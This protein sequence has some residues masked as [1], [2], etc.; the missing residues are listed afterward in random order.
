MGEQDFA[1]S[2]WRNDGQSQ[3]Q[4]VSCSTKQIV[5]GTFSL[6]KITVAG[7]V[8]LKM[9][10]EI[11]M[12]GLRCHHIL[13]LGFEILGSHFPKKIDWYRRPYNLARSFP[14][15]RPL[16]FFFWGYIKMVLRITTVHH[17][18]GR[19]CCGR[20]STRHVDKCLVSTWIQIYQ[21]PGQ[22][23]CPHATSAVLVMPICGKNVHHIT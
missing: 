2:D 17:Q 5:L 23:R 4:C 11:L 6:T 7:A 3:F 18:V 20:I 19:S 10:E 1:Y 13:A 21:V 15:R 12:V 9:L 22:L 16:Y 14:W 8:Y